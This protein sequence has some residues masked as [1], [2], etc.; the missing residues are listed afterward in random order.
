MRAALIKSSPNLLIFIFIW[1]LFIAEVNVLV[2]SWS[3]SAL[4]RVKRNSLWL[5]VCKW[6]LVKWIQ[7]HYTHFLL[8]CSWP[9]STP[10]L[11]AKLAN[12]KKKKRKKPVP[13][14]QSRD[15]SNK[16]TDLQNRFYS[17]VLWHSR[18]ENGHVSRIPHLARQ[19]GETFSNSNTSLLIQLSLWPL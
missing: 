8:N 12:L 15:M 1:K 13:L 9:L 7:W 2:F 11:C 19:A 14:S 18:R 5:N 16:Q 3:L 4:M 10:L 17:Q 6:S